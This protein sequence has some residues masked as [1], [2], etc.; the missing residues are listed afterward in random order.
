MISHDEDRGQRP[1]ES[2]RAVSCIRVTGHVAVWACVLVPSILVLARGWTPLGDYA[3]IELRAYRTFSLHPPL[4]GM[5]STATSSVGHTVSDP[6]PLSFWLLA[7]P[8]RADP[9]HGLIWG[10]AL[11]WGLALSLAIEALWASGIRL[12]CAV[13]PLA[14][15]DLL[16]VAPSVLENLAWNAYLP[17]PFLLAA[18]CLAFLV[19]KGHFGWWPVL[20]FVASVAGQ[21]HLL[22]LIPSLALALAAPVIGVLVAGRPTRLR[23]LPWGFGVALACWAAPLLQGVGSPS[24]LVALAT[25]TGGTSPMGAGFGL[26]TI[27]DSASFPPIW[28]HRVPTGFFPEMAFAFG[29]SPLYGTFGVL[30]ILA[31]PIVAMVLRDRSLFAVGVVTV[32]TLLGLTVS[33]AIIPSASVAVVGYVLVVLWIEGWLLWLSAGWCVLALSS[34]LV[35]SRV[36]SRPGRGSRVE[37]RPRRPRVSRLIWSPGTVMVVLIAAGS[38][39]AV[40]DSTAANPDFGTNWSPQEASETSRIVTLVERRFG[41]GSVNVAVTSS[42]RD[43]APAVAVA[44]GVGLQLLLGNGHPGIQGVDPAF[45]SLPPRAAAAKISVRIG[46]GHVRTEATSPPR[47]YAAGPSPPRS[48]WRS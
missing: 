36:E 29:H 37:S 1:K 48:P 44:E 20:V 45:T 31:V 30:V 26:R 12:G 13:A 47:P 15:A 14:V 43:P 34:S 16:W 4:V 27:G 42:T 19:V 6:G 5:Y 39:L 18:A 46:A 33:F 7:G 28:L 35:G 40:S 2:T 17:L 32:L 23:W 41:T 38:A 10:S 21:T 9:A 22:Y 24:N 25:G 3:A 11:L 8:V